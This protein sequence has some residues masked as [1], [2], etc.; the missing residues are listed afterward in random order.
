MKFIET[1]NTNNR[2]G[3]LRSKAT[4]EPAVA[5]GYVVVSALRHALSSV[6]KDNGHNDTFLPLG[7]LEIIFRNFCTQLIRHHFAGSGLTPDE[8]CL[9]APANM[10]HF[11][12]E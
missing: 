1:E 12:I 10:E 2:V 6:L 9:A 5:L 11:L 8:L 7:I 3:V 4:G